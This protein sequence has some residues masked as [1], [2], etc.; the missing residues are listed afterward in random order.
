MKPE[1]YNLVS[2]T[3]SYVYKQNPTLTLITNIETRKEQISFT[4]KT[5]KNMIICTEL[6]DDTGYAKCHIAMI[7]YITIDHFK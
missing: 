3:K 4:N 6:Y 2:Q 1:K 7:L 5:T